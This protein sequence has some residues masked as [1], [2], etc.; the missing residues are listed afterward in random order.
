MAKSG[1]TLTTTTFATIASVQLLALFVL[2]TPSGIVW[3]RAEGVGIWIIGA[4]YATSWLLLMRANWDAGVE[5]QSGLLG[6]MSLLR[7]VKPQYPPMPT[8]GLFTFVRQPIYVAFALTTWAVPTWTP[9]QLMVA[10]T[11]TIHCVV[12]PAFKERRLSRRHNDQ[13]QDY[14]A[15]TPYWTPWAK[16]RRTLVRRIY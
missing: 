11:L 15:R 12:G 16:T 8:T 3:W 14:R 5:V 2:W 13:W 4:L 10:V 9:D 6:W 1:E 7:G